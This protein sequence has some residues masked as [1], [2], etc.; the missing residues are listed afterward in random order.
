MFRGDILK[1]AILYIHGKGGSFLEAQ[2]YKTICIGFDVIGVDYEQYLPWIV[3]NQ[4][5]TV[6]D[7]LKKEYEH[8]SIIANS[9]GAYFAMHT[10]QNCNIKKALLISPIL[11]MERLILDMMQWANVTEKELWEKKEILT[12][13]G[14]T[15]SWEY[16]KFVRE[17]PIKWE[18]PTEILYAGQD[19][20]TSRKTVETFI[21]SHNANLTVME[22]GEHWFHTEEQVTF[23]DKWIKNVI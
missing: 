8:I 16:L 18:I 6:Y 7:D 5:K 22:N 13:F 9:I 21:E 14:E 2:R 11:D 10:L 3:Q 20:L 4:I 19:N 15:L 1:K 17:N 12:D 23:L